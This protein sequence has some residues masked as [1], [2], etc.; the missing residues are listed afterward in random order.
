MAQ[1]P[2]KLSKFDNQPW[3]FRIQGGKDFSVPITV[4]K[5]NGG[6]LAER[7]GLNAGDTIVA[8]N[9]IDA[10][11]LRHKEAQDAIVRAGNNFEMVVVRGNIW[12]PV[13]TPLAEPK[14]QQNGEPTIL[15]K[16][17]LAANQQPKRHIL[18]NFYNSTP[19]PY[20]GRRTSQ[21]KENH[22]RSLFTQTEIKNNTNDSAWQKRID[23]SEINED[24]CNS[25]SST[26][27]ENND[28]P[29]HVGSAHNLQPAPFGK[30]VPITNGHAAQT[31]LPLAK[32][33]NS[34]AGL[35]SEESIAETLT[36][37][38]EVLAQGVL[39]VNFKKNERQYDPAQSEV[40]KMIQEADSAPRA[41]ETGISC[42]PVESPRKGSQTP[43]I[44]SHAF[45]RLQNALLTEQKDPPVPAMSS[46]PVGV[47]PV[48]PPKTKPKD[49][50][51]INVPDLTKCGDC[52]K[53]IVGIF[54]KIKGKNLHVECFKCATCGTSLKNIGYYDIGGKLYCD[55]HARQAAKHNTP[56]EA[57]DHDNSDQV[58]SNDLPRQQ[59]EKLRP[60]AQATA[61]LQAAAAQSR[62]PKTP[63]IG[64]VRVFPGVLFEEGVREKAQPPTPRPRVEPPIPEPVEPEATPESLPG[65]IM[66]EEPIQELPS[67]QLLEPKSEPTEDHE[68]IKNLTL[69]EEIEVHPEQPI[70]ENGIASTDEVLGPLGEAGQSDAKETPLEVEA[71]DTE[72]APIPDS[73]P[74]QAPAPEP[75]PVSRQVASPIP[76]V[77]KAP[78]FSPI[79]PIKQ[80]RPFSGDYAAFAPRPVGTR[81]VWPPAKN[82]ENDPIATATP[83]YF[84]PGTRPE[85]F[86]ETADSHS[87]E[88]ALQKTSFE[89]FSSSSLISKTVV[90]MSSQVAQSTSF[91]SSNQTLPSI[92]PV[93][94]P[95]VLEPKPAPSVENTNPLARPTHV[96]FAPSLAPKPVAAFVP[97]TTTPVIP[98]TLPK[99]VVAPAAVFSSASNASV[100]PAPSFTAP[101]MP[102]PAPAAPVVGASGQTTSAPR[103]GKGVLSQK[104]GPGVRIP[105]CSACEKQIRGPFVTALGRNWCPEHFVCAN[106]SCKR[107]LQDTG[108]VE[109]KNELYCESCFENYLAPICDKCQKRVV[110]DCLKAIGKQ[111]HPECFA[112]A[113]CGRLFGNSRFYLEDGLPYC[114]ADWNE[115]FTT[116]C[117]GCGFPIEAGDRWVEAMN[118]NYH[119]QCFNCSVCKK[120]LEGQ[121]FLAKG[122]KPMCKSHATRI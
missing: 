1:V 96:A 15:T 39:G 91:M 84:P 116:K 64:G 94:A 43:L 40:L 12:K 11:K 5:V 111:F 83:L 41:H 101:Y 3:G 98:A 82:P 31:A 108:F 13:V 50:D 70:L 118:N 76:P 49:D 89:S 95:V 103:R 121:S 46:R 18:G 78:T 17:S 54:V 97:A 45:R 93:Q 87:M 7:A 9:G 33:Y 14:I 85:S 122:G 47:R 30:K 44:Q 86:V 110:G 120:N 53:I 117:F 113:Y 77:I 21:D 62:E 37:Q 99:P 36:A 25:V 105:V 51:P 79:P 42:E 71:V 119:S 48:E 34:P 8:I 10:L 74:A 115:L 28:A 73:V 100:V 24:R 4:Q 56:A 67:E 109:E 29:R 35:Y 72:G 2:I 32:Q 75:I 63:P 80:E 22:L 6:S 106:E 92:K 57:T 61:Q 65:T 23:A 102:G 16:T 26:S 68:D 27:S 58:P 60:R 19:K 69:Q 81:F 107:H 114:E 52:D 104:V 66:V 55:M 112:C 38:A 59:L 20:L 88:T 90:E